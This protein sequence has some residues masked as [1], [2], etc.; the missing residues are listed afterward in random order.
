LSGRD[1]SGERPERE[2][3]GGDCERSTHGG[4]SL[5]ALWRG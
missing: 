3:D 5:E 1:G 4:S 2:H